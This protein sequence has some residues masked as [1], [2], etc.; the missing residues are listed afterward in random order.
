MYTVHDVSKRSGVSVRTLH[1]YDAVGL[2]K[3]AAVTP[4]GYRLYDADCLQR[5]Q[6]IMFLREL[7]FSLKAI[8]EILDSPDYD[9]QKALA[10]QIELLELQK[11]RLERIIKQAKKL[12]TDMF[13]AKKTR[14]NIP[15]SRTASRP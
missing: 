2:L 6:N 8:G 1:H 4:A 11:D 3:P 12:V 5:L 14:T 10:Q 7:Q 13:F 9:P 15:I